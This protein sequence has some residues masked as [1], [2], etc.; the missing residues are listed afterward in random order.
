[1]LHD[2]GKMW[3]VTEQL[4]KTIDVEGVGSLTKEQYHEYVC[5]Q[6]YVLG[7][8]PPSD[9]EIAKAFNNLDTDQHGTA[10]MDEFKADVRVFLTYLKISLM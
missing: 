4:F 2:E 3:S 10:D 1:V 5:Q 8:D 7:N 6:A 9:K